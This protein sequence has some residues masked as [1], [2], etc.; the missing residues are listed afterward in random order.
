MELKQRDVPKELLIFRSLISREYPSSVEFER[1]YRRKEKGYAGEVIFD[2]FLKTINV[3]PLILSDL[4]L[5]HSGSE[6]Q[7]DSILV[8][9][10]VINIFEVKNMEGDY[11]IEKGKWY[12]E[13]EYEV[14]NPIIQVERSL[15][16]FRPL[17]RK[18]KCN[19]PIQAYV[20]FVNPEF[21]LLQAPRDLK[22]ILPSQINRFLR[23]LNGQTSQ[24][25]QHHMDV[26]NQLIS[27]HKK[28]SSNSKLPIFTLDQLKK[29]C[30]CKLLQGFYAT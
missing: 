29:K 20:I 11:Y 9:Q 14:K 8:F 10:H 5:E 26:A 25:N 23:K 28:E 4:L 19:L 27:L 6:F 3:E 1:K 13:P 24:W 17:L 18:L 2:N 22:I 16:S 30:Y 21:T 7:L 12:L 15:E